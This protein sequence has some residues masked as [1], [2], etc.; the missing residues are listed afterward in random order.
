MHKAAVE[1]RPAPRLIA[2]HS[3]CVAVA[4]YPVGRVFK[5]ELPGAARPMAIVVNQVCQMANGLEHARTKNL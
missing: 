2:D 4:Q 1:I 5:L 3:K